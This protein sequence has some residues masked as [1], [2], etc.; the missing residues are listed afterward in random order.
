MN[1]TKEDKAII[2]RALLTR[3]SFH[4]WTILYW[5]IFCPQKSKNLLKYIKEGM[6]YEFAFRKA[7]QNEK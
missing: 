5:D 2:Y 1:M 4:F 3:R 7:K 6:S